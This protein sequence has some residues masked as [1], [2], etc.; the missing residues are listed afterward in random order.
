MRFDHPEP[1]VLHRT[2]EGEGLDLYEKVHTLRRQDDWIRIHLC[3]AEKT[4]PTIC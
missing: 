4:V 3:V 1:I 2:K